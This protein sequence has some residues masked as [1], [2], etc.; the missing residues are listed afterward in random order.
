MTSGAMAEAVAPEILFVVIR[1]TILEGELWDNVYRKIVKC[2][3]NADTVLKIFF[4]I[5]KRK[6]YNINVLGVEFARSFILA[7]G[8]KV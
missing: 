1:L 5:I 6:V 3:E 7:N 8:D 2:R 4:Y